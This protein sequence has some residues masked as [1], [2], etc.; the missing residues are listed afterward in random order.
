MNNIEPSKLYTENEEFVNYYTSLIGLSLSIVCFIF[1]LLFSIKYGSAIHIT[2]STIYGIS[3]V[4]MYVASTFYHGSNEKFKNIF[5]L[6]DHSSIFIYIAGSYTPFT[7]INLKGPWGY[8]IFTIIWILAIIGIILK[9]TL[10]EKASIITMILYILMGWTIIVAIKPLINNLNPNAII[11][12][13]TGGISYTLGLVFYAWN[14]L[15]Y[16]HGIWHIFVMIGS[17]T[18]FFA[19]LFYVI[20]FFK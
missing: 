7:L 1:L 5:R 15:P 3:M 6:I 12:L 18:H 20:P 2:C 14:S 8:S 13:F 9:L 17:F 4:F 19:V 10:R 16:N 11:L